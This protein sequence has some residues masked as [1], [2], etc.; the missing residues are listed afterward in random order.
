MNQGFERIGGIDLK[1]WV[2]LNLKKVR[3][4]EQLM[5]G[6]RELSRIL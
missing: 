1:P 6:A 4:N 2:P 3:S 5:M